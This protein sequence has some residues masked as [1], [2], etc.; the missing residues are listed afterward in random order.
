MKGKSNKAGKEGWVEIKAGKLA[1]FLATDMLRLQASVDTDKDGKKTGKDKLTGLNYQILQAHLA[2]FGRDKQLLPQLFEQSKLISSDNPHP[3]LHKI[4][5]NDYKDIV[6]FYQAYLNERLKY[7]ERCEKEKDYKAY[8][9]LKPERNKWQAKEAKYYDELIKTYLEMPINLPRGLFKEA[10]VAWFQENGSLEIKS[11]INESER[12]NTIYLLQKYFEYDFHSDGSQ[13]FYSY[14]RSYELINTLFDHRKGG[15]KYK[16][17]DRQ[18]L[19]RAEL[20][21]KMKSL[22]DKIARLPEENEVHIRAKRKKEFVRLT[23]NEKVIRHTKASDMLLFLLAKEMLF[24]QLNKAIQQD[25]FKLSDIKPNGD[26]DILSTSIPFCLPLDYYETNEKGAITKERILLGAKVIHQKALKI[27]NYGDFR[28]F[29]NDRRLNMLFQWIDNDRIERV[30]LEKELEGYDKARLEAAHCIYHFENEVCQRLMMVKKP[31][32]TY[33]GNEEILE[34][35]YAQFPQYAVER[36]IIKQIRNA[37]S[38]NQYPDVTI[39]PAGFSK[40]FP[41]IALG[42]VEW[43]KEKMN[44]YINALQTIKQGQ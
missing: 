13:E 9:F 28:R 10:L 30:D 38:H 31:N 39:F 44:R 16:P 21:S 18:F 8:Y 34:A 23:K 42:I 17:K 27:K 26:K 2:F 7:F 15:D 3:F 14:R 29:V 35:F 4:N 24:D 20:E 32:K 41:G 40:T 37:F 6:G 25:D 1:D 19:T 33:V 22:K 36:P 5:A 11:L 43:L 12:V